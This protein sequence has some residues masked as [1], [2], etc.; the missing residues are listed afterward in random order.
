METRWWRLGVIAV[1]CFLLLPALATG[2]APENAPLWLP[3]AGGVKRTG[4]YLTLGGGALLFLA[5]LL[6]FA[7]RQRPE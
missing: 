4:M 3:L 1:G 5:A 7:T 6:L 2:A